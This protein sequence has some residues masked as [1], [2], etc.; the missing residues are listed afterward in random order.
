MERW[1]DI[2]GWNG[3]YQVSSYGRVR[4]CIRIGGRGNRYTKD[5]PWRII[6]TQVKRGYEIL[7]IRKIGKTKKTF[8][9]LHRVMWTAF[10]GEI[11]ENMTIDHINGDK[12]DNRLENLRLATWQQQSF[13]RPKQKRKSYSKYKGINYQKSSPNKPWLAFIFY[14]NKK[15]YLGHFATEVEAAKAYNDAAIKFFGEFAKLNIIES[16]II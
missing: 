9:A 8:T 2:L 16:L 7:S 3:F 11:P 10:N 6:K 4:T 14:N 15:I 13:N 1:A 12:R 5:N